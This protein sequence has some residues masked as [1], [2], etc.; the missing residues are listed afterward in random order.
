MLRTKFGQDWPSSS[1]E[2]DVR[3][4]HDDRR[5]PKAIG[6][7]GDS[8]D[9]NTSLNNIYFSISNLH[10]LSLQ[11]IRLGNKPMAYINPSLNKLT[12]M[13]ETRYYIYN[14]T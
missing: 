2:E 9:I 8:D 5:Q 10:E 12:Y 1:R 3:T 6:H 13:R 14:I 11:T 7:L 4:T